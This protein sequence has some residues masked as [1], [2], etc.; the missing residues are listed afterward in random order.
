LTACS[1]NERSAERGQLDGDDDRGG[2]IGGSEDRDEEQA[3]FTSHLSPAGAEL[4]RMAGV[5]DLRAMR[6]AMIAR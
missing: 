3:A 6:A 4:K 5:R 2:L 1:G